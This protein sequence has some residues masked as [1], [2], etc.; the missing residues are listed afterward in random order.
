MIDRFL[1]SIRRH[2]IRWALGSYDQQSKT[3]ELSLCKCWENVGS[4]LVLWPAKGLDIVAAEIVLNRLQERFPGTCIT[5][6]AL[7][8]IGASPPQEMNVKVIHVDKKSFNILG[9]PQR[10]LRDEI[11][12]VRAD[13]AIDLSPKFNVL[14][15]YL[16]RISRARISISFADPRGDSAYNF[17][18]APGP[19]R[20]GLDRY[21]TLARY[22]G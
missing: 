7:P 6:L 15:A 10:R 21:R 14:S 9:L 8:G 22:I 12:A 11:L 1:N 16:C 3:T 2:I 19:K 17:Q 13:V 20:E 4:C 5:L 18:V